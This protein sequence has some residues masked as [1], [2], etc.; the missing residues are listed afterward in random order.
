MG[1]EI[2]DFIL[3]FLMGYS[4]SKSK[5]KKINPQVIMFITQRVKH[6]TK[7]TITVEIIINRTKCQ[8]K[9]FLSQRQSNKG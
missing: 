1:Y 8:K 9:F 2:F 3:S 7:Q 4:K 6:S 5:W